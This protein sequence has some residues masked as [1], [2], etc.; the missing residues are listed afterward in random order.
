MTEGGVELTEP[1][2]VVAPYMPGIDYD[3][4]EKLEELFTRQTKVWTIGKK[5]LLMRWKNLRKSNIKRRPLPNPRTMSMPS[6]T[7]LS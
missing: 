6:Y 3:N 7:Y 5:S 1:E 4:E 2:E